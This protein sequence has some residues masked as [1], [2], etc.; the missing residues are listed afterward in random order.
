[1][2]LL[3][4]DTE[5]TGVV[6][7]P[8]DY[9]YFSDAAIG[10]ALSLAGDGIARACATL[11]KQLALALTI[12]GQSIKADDFSINT[13]GKGKDL[14]EVANSFTRQADDEDAR[15]AREEDGAYA[16]VNS[17]LRPIDDPPVGM[18]GLFGR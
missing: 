6:G 15:S 3:L 12:A 11:V 16:I 10:L 13:L 2:R 18:A 8:G 9:A 17:R 5:A 4:G 1:M 7:E 14:L